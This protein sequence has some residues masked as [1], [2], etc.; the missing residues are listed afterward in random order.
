MILGTAFISLERGHT[1]SMDSVGPVTYKKG[2]IKYILIMTDSYTHMG[3]VWKFR[4]IFN[5]NVMKVILEWIFRHGSM[6]TL[7]W[8]NTRYFSSE[9]LRK[10]CA[11]KG[12]EQVF[13]A[14]YRHESVGLVERYQQTLVDRLRKMTLN[15]DGFN[16]RFW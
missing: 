9:E 6:V 15:R 8:D 13:I 11:G 12:I 14:P 7:V 16:K 4:I 3:G 2:G 1:S 10:W 5:R